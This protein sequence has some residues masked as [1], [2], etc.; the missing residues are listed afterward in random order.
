MKA[1]I[2]LDN[3]ATTRMD[4]RVF[5][6]MSRRERPQADRGAHRGDAE[7]DHFHQRRD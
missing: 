1:P 2:Y 4:P 6:A 7:R 5:Q 3:Q